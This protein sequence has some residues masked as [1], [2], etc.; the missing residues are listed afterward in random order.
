MK[1]SRSIEL[2]KK[3]EILFKGYIDEISLNQTIENFRIF[4]KNQRKFLY[5]KKSVTT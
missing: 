5:L 4:L 2:I 1:K 3:I